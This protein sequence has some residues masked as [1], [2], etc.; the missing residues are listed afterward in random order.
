M[1]SVKVH[2]TNALHKQLDIVTGS[3]VG[4]LS[5]TITILM[6]P[7]KSVTKTILCSLFLLHNFMQFPT[8]SY[9]WPGR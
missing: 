4:L 6:N 9:G 2:D 8:L 7:V 3:A 5:K 1:R